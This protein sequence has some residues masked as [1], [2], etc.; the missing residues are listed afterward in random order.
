VLWRQKIQTYLKYQLLLSFVGLILVVFLVVFPPKVTAVFPWRKPLIGSIFSIFCFLGFI[1]VLSP[2]K[3]GK[4]LE[5]KKVTPG[6]SSEKYV[7]QKNSFAL[8]GHHPTCGKYSEHVFH[9][10][11]KTYCAA[12]TGLLVGGLLSLVG[13]VIYFYVGLNI[14]EISM[15]FV[16][17]GV[18]GVIIGMFQFAFKSIFRLLANTIFVLGSLLILIAVDAIVG[19]LF[20][21]LFVVCLII[22]WLFTRISFS[23]WDHKRICFICGTENCN[24]RT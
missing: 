5:H 1:A 14:I 10:K 17:L 4:M 9:I 11:A 15:L 21:D 23:K 22:F 2:S 20:F 18:F 3:C 13:S 19:G 12:C 8:I 24:A 6:I 16:V 7:S